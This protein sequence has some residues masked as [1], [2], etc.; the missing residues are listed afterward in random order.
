[1]VQLSEL[2]KI[3]FGGYRISSNSKE[4]ESALHYAI[5]CGCNL[6]DTASNYGN[7]ESEKLIG[8]VL[9]KIPNNK[10]FVITK[11]GC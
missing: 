1:M 6:I 2:S 7:G 11:A 5:Q 10:V 9:Q 4:N 3:G 8:K